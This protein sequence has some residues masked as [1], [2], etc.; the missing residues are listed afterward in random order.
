MEEPGG[1]Q[2]TNPVGETATDLGTGDS[3]YIAADAVH[4]YVNPG[5]TPCVCYVAALIMRS[6]ARRT[7]TRR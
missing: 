7:P 4:G 2:R 1:R 5:G 6:R 3:A